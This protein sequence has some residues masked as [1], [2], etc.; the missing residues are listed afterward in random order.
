MGVGLFVADDAIHQHP[1]PN[2]TAM[3]LRHRVSDK[4]LDLLKGMLSS[5]GGSRPTID[6]ILAHP[7]A[8]EQ[9]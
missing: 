8:V 2:L 9:K 6:Q 1:A 4:A 7:W 3:N 5:Q